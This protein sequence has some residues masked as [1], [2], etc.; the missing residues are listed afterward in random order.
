[1]RW[2]H[3]LL[4]VPGQQRKVENQSDPISIDEEEEGQESVNGGLWNDVGVE[5]VAEI[6]RIDVIAGTEY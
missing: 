1:M 4:P 5:A 2:G 3:I 6:D